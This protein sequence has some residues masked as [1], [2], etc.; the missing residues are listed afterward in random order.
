MQVGVHYTS[1]ERGPGKVVHNL[2]KGLA[3]TGVQYIS[4]S[5][6]TLN[7]ILQPTKRL[8]GN[9]S[10]CFIG[11]NICTLPIENSTVMAYNSYAKIIVP[12]DWV[13]NLYTRWIPEDKII[14]WPVGIDIDTFVDYSKSDKEFDFLVYHKR[15]SFS[16]LQHI[17]SFLEQQGKTYTVVSYGDY[18]EEHFLSTIRKSR[19]GI[20]V[21]GTESQGIA[22]QEMMSCNLPLLVWDVGEWNDMGPEHA[23]PATSIPYWDSTCGEVFYSADE[24]ENVY[25]VFINQNYKP[26]DYITA[27]LNINKQA[28]ILLNI[29][30]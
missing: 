9:L 26:R 4:N 30:I 17:T 16:E 28:E 1:T 8:S 3:N 12:S 21:A 18:S 5:E 14:A 27:N 11:P 7:I 19:R 20:V 29:K 22:I 25:D 6:G 23:C 24:L 10:N 15:R 13:K 2:L